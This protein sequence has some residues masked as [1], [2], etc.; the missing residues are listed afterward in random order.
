MHTDTSAAKRQSGARI[1][2][3]LASHQ[4]ANA[5]RPVAGFREG[6]GGALLRSADVLTW[7][8][9]DWENLVADLGA[10]G[11]VTIQ[12]LTRDAAMSASEAYA[13]AHFSPDRQAVSVI[14][15]GVDLRLFLNDW[16]SGAA[17][18]EDSDAAR[19]PGLHFFARD[20]RLF[21]RLFLRKGSD[22]EAYRLLVARYGGARVPGIHE[23]PD[24]AAARTRVRDPAMVTAFV[25]EWRRL[26]DLREYRILL[27]RFGVSP[28]EAASLLGDG[29]AARVQVQAFTACMRLLAEIDLSCSITVA[30]RGVVQTC[31]G[32]IHGV[33]AA[34][35][36][37]A[38]FA[39]RASVWLRRHGMDSVWVVR[40]PTADG[41]SAALEVYDAGGELSLRVCGNPG[42]RNHEDAIW[43]DILSTL[44]E[45][46]G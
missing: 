6:S 17:V 38:V 29:W 26:N 22:L 30:N 1:P 16:F 41:I 33:R 14:G 34:E 2:Q 13:E 4:R 19:R 11:P 25:A 12:T 32:P 35:D 18:C 43:E 44:P 5:A 9:P 36:G 42:W 24:A 21:H 3:R 46:D 23:V 10:V 7:L 8:T 20:G 45:F 15:E 40:R 28:L 39:A 27:D 37:L 31:R